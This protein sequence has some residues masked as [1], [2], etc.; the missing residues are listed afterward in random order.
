MTSLLNGGNLRTVEKDFF[1]P[2]FL[3]KLP[4]PE[5]ETKQNEY[6]ERT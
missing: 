2:Y 4:F 3:F 1:H 6:P 5:G